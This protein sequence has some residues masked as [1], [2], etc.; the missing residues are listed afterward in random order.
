MKKTSL[1]LTILFTLIV[2]LSGQNNEENSVR[3]AFDSYKTAILNDK[4]EE[5]VNYVDS[6]T[7]QYYTDMLDLAKNG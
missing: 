2:T 3:N 4:G 6:R 7:I 1:V 5:A